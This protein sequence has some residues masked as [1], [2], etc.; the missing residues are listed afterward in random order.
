M[1]R[2]AA[3]P[4]GQK[5]PAGLC[6]GAG[7]RLTAAGC[8]LPADGGPEGPAGPPDPALAD[9]G[10]GALQAAAGAAAAAAARVGE[11]QEHLRRM[12]GCEERPYAAGRGPGPCGTVCGPLSNAA[13]LQSA[14][15]LALLDAL[16]TTED[17]DMLDAVVAACEGGQL[18][19]AAI[20]RLR[21]ALELRLG[22]SAAGRLP[23]DWMGLRAAQLC[24]GDRLSNRPAL[25]RRAAVLTDWQ[26][27]LQRVAAD[28]RG[29]DVVVACGSGRGDPQPA[30]E[31]APGWA[32]RGGR[33]EAPEGPVACPAT[34]LRAGDRVV[35]LGS[36]AY[37]DRT[38]ADG[39]CG[40]LLR[41]DGSGNSE[42]LFDGDC[43]SRW[44]LRG[45]TP[46]LARLVAPLRWPCERCHC[47]C[48]VALAAAAT[49]LAAAA[50]APEW[51]PSGE[52]A[53]AASALLRTGALLGVGAGGAALARGALRRAE[54]DRAARRRK[55]ARSGGPADPAPQRRRWPFPEAGR[56]RD[57]AALRS[58]ASAVPQ[59]AQAVA[60]AAA[61]DAERAQRQRAQRA[62]TAVGR[63]WDARVRDAVRAH[64]AE[65]GRLEAQMRE[66][67][68][69][70]LL[71]EAK[72]LVARLA[73]ELTAQCTVP[74]QG[75]TGRPRIPVPTLIT[76][77]G[78]LC[79]RDYQRRGLDWLAALHAQQLGGILADDMGLG[80]TI[81]TIS[82]LAHIA[83]K[84]W[85]WGQHLVVVP[86]SVLLNW[87]DE[88][89]RWAPGLRVLAY[90]GSQERRAALR[91][92]W[93]KQPPQDTNFDVCVASYATVVADR[94]Y[95]RRVEWCYLVLDEAHHIK[96]WRS[97][98]WRVV[99]E[100]H[101]R[102][103]LVLTGTPLQNHMMELW[104]LLRF[105][106]PAS[107]LFESG[108]DF[109]R[110][111]NS[112]LLRVVSNAAPPAALAGA[113]S[114]L[115]RVLRP[116]MLRRTKREVESQLP[117]KTE[118]VLRCP[119]ARRQRGLYDEYVRRPSTKR[120]LNEGYLHVMAVIMA[121]RKV[122][123][124]PNLFE[125]RPTLSPLVLHPQSGATAGALHGFNAGR[126]MPRG[127]DW[128]LWAAKGAALRALGLCLAVPAAAPP[129]T[130]GA[131]A[132]RGDSAWA[133]RVWDG[134]WDEVD[135]RT[136]ARLPQRW[137]LR[138]PAV[139]AASPAPL[140]AA[141][142]GPSG[143]RWSPGRLR[144]IEAGTAQSGAAAQA[145][146]V[147]VD[148][149][150]A[151]GGAPQLL[152]RRVVRHCS[153]TAVDRQFRLVRRRPRRVHRG[154]APVAPSGCPPRWSCGAR[155]GGQQCADGGQQCADCVEYTERCGGPLPPPPPESADWVAWAAPDAARGARGPP[156]ADAP[157]RPLPQL[158]SAPNHPS[159]W[160]CGAV[161][162]LCRA[163]GSNWQEPPA[164]PRSPP[165]DRTARGGRREQSPERGETELDAA[166]AEQVCDFLTGH[167]AEPPPPLPGRPA[168]RAARHRAQRAA[169]G[170]RVRW[171][172]GAAWSAQL[173]LR[174]C[175]GLAAPAAPD[176]GGAAARP[177]RVVPPAALAA[178]D[179]SGGPRPRAPSAAAPLAGWREQQ[180]VLPEGRLL[181][182]DCGKLQLL[183]TLLPRLRRGGHR[184]LI[185][186]QMS[187]VL[188]ILEG[189][190]SRRGFPYLRLDGSTPPERRHQLM[191]LF[192][193]PGRGSAPNPYFCFIL[194]TRSGGVGMN[195]C[196]ADTVIFYDSDWNP[197]MDS[198]A[199]DRAHR[200]GQTKDVTVYRLISAGTIEEN[201]LLKARQK[202]TLVNLVISGGGFSA[203]PDARAQSGQHR[204]FD[205]MEFFHHLDEGEAERLA[206]EYEQRAAE[207]H[208]PAPGEAPAPDEELLCVED[209]ADQEACRRLREELRHQESGS[210]D[211][212]GRA[213]EAAGP[214][215]PPPDEG[216]A[217]VAGG[218]PL[219]RRCA[220]FV[221]RHFPRRA[222]LLQAE[223]AA[224]LR[225]PG[226][227]PAPRHSRSTSPGR[228]QRRH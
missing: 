88:F 179:P 87:Q 134:V 164:P 73:A 39:S 92:G 25:L 217:A 143:L 55:R 211:D 195:L 200:I 189:F 130:W 49:A 109:D 18:P 180:L 44:V 177:L 214:S 167:A 15:E 128:G 157:R 67:R 126:A 202:R 36:V 139:L 68:K 41:V 63:W 206:R 43:S 20:L 32:V 170:R 114:E 60:A 198:Q 137:E 7:G 84:E 140:P 100:L 85:L 158:C 69:M 213:L 221:V 152:G 133:Q 184:C 82:L 176:C 118:R 209:E 50:F 135:P 75:L 111:F 6:C 54:Q 138:Y 101:S 199:Q 93:T 159:H 122:C 175:G 21:V 53:G 47:S 38:V 11:E 172:P 187:K 151:G 163:A 59:K 222:L 106:M 16:S 192:N 220:E 210:G 173:T 77:A 169:S 105:L 155:R 203:A 181:E 99:S 107:R 188:D 10:A 124:H 31:V 57:A 46:Q 79:M 62:A 110:W 12:L 147:E 121:L 96:N 23:P 22:P 218:S 71:G 162:P 97:Q 186:T 66:E 70:A 76:P 35:L 146:Q 171:E 4:A 8:G 156:A 19:A 190:L 42:V 132:G 61:R 34:G 56:G 223:R 28:P 104:S 207:R 65:T 154:G 183:A 142:V 115:H 227:G 27:A 205:P 112:P 2:W 185:F 191:H 33:E 145:V 94:E 208:S 226:G 123:N 165:P 89:E 91:N 3:G 125:P 201:M 119:L 24:G 136:G 48:P 86:T 64:R 161:A 153:G 178:P 30:P 216:A 212:A 144:F 224:R 80:K 113:V 116:F 141:A 120:R 14:A 196:G 13:L 204:R 108:G 149:R 193:A 90:H 81:Q 5:P 37:E 78:G 52:S 45:S 95:F 150:P 148:L 127:P 117:R 1:I 131:D 98:R 74:E 197:A 168:G 166:R 160:G 103:R 72:S 225:D 51:T 228:K 215:L 219:E 9:G 129:R 29:P 174:R 40:D 83:E 26:H 58:L 182:H 102:H 194:S 17:R